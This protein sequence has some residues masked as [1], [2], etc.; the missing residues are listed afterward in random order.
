MFTIQQFVKV[1]SLEEAFQLNQKK[2]SCI[3]GGMLWTKMTKNPVNTAIDMSD[4]G[5]NT[6]EETDEQF[7]IGAYVTLRQIEQHQGF[8]AYTENIAREAVQDIVGVQFRNLATVGGSIWG[9]FG[10]SDVLTMFMALDTYVELYQGGIIPLNEFVKMKYDRDI[11][12]RII[13][14]K[15]TGKFV[16]SAVRNQSTDFPVIVCTASKANGKYRFV[17]GARP[18]KAMLLTDENGYL[19]D[20]LTDEAI[21]RFS[22]WAKELIPT[23]SNTRASAEYRSYLIGVLCKRLLVRLREEQ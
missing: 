20:G 13:V 4:L 3:L 21:D 11:L 10:F 6:I 5:L 19:A 7:T 23:G 17:A 18:N 1:K 14:K 16:Y 2:G 12:V 15:E 9:R 8:N 22:A